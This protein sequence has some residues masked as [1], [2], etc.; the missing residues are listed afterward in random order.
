MSCCHHFKSSSYYYAY[1]DLILQIF[2]AGTIPIIVIL[3]LGDHASSSADCSSHSLS[4][5][6]QLRGPGT[7]TKCSKANVE[8]LVA[9]PEKKP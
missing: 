8:G 6:Q 7:D 3:I 2:L 1:L 9:T 4:E 5:V